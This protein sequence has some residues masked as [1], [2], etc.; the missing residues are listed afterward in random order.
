MA[1]CA[2]SRIWKS[3]KQLSILKVKDW[4]LISELELIKYKKELIIYIYQ[5]DV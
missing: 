5:S 2:L 1:L 4:S 3:I